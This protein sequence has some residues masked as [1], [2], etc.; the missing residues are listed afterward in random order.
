ML[1]LLG[2]I[3]VTLFVGGLPAFRAFGANFLVDTD[4]DPVQDIYGGA[5][6]IYGTLI[7]SVIALVISV[8]IS[9]GIAIFL[10]LRA[11]RQPGCAARSAP[12]SNCWPPCRP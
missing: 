1:V 4:W 11:G 7:T 10:T 12:P 5:V 2:A 3:I 8:P 6:P 9:F